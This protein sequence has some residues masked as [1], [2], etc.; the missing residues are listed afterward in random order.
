MAKKTSPL[1]VEILAEGVWN[2]ISFTAD[3]MDEMVSNFKGLSSVLDV[4]LKLG[5][6][7][8]AKDVAV[9]DGQPAMGWVSELYLNGEGKLMAEL[10]DLPAVV[11]DA[12]K[13]KLYKTVSI[14]A[15]L[16]V[17]YKGKEYG[18]VLSGL[19]LLGATLPAVNTLADLQTYLSSTSKLEFSAK[20]ASGQLTEKT[21]G[22][23]MTEAEMNKLVAEAEAK[24]AVAAAR[25][26]TLSAENT[27]AQAEVKKHQ[28]LLVESQ[29]LVGLAQFEKDKVEL[30]TQLESLVKAGTITPGV[31]DGLDKLIKDEETLG[32]VKL[33]VKVLLDGS[34]V[35]PGTDET[36][37]TEGDEDK[38]EKGMRPDEVVHARAVKFTATSPNTTYSEAVN[39]VMMQ[40]SKLAES[41]RDQHDAEGK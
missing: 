27:A 40:D 12:I 30:S 17:K 8:D 11:Y 13:S 25:V 41:Y 14:E 5:H 4:P 7:D 28:E 1:L 19:A 10:T 36:A 23:T 22:E 39:V 32:S 20:L 38:G 16:D 29:K 9:R 31:R 3:M 21:G 2:G 24:A 33:S 34:K 6:T 37:K 26:T 35:A 15:L 18:T